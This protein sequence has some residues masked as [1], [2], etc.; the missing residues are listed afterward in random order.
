MAFY[1]RA[2]MHEENVTFRD[3]TGRQEEVVQERDAVLVHF[4]DE[5]GAC[6]FATEMEAMGM[7]SA[8][9][10]G[11]LLWSERHFPLKAQRLGPSMLACEVV[12]ALDRVPFFVE[13]A[14]RLGRRFGVALAFEVFVARGEID[15]R[16]CVVIASF[17][18]NNERFDYYLRLV[19][20]QLLTRAGVRLGARPYGFGIWNSPFLRRVFSAQE[21]QAMLRDKRAADPHGLLNPQKFFSVRSRMHNIPGLL[22]LPPVYEGLLALGTLLAPILGF[23]ARTFASSVG[24]P[25]Q[26][27][28]ED[29]ADGSTLVK[30]T[31]MRC[32]SCGACISV[33]PAFLVTGREL[34]AGRAKLKIAR[35]VL[36]RATITGSEVATA[37]QCLHCGLC[38]EVCQTRLP[39]RACYRVLERWAIRRYGLPRQVIQEFVSRVD[40]QR[41]RVLGAYGLARAEWTPP[42]PPLSAAVDRQG[43]GA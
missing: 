43:V 41:L 1:D 39:L 25:W 32:A 14:R 31:E 2:R 6:R 21:R 34:V 5:E 40:E 13:K 35:A 9:V 7:V 37:F 11:S 8:Q 38:E 17:L 15:E 12:L 16:N 27:P 23:V 3:K 28:S 42:V 29:D 26:T 30:E 18:C 36:E 19:L 4:D 10:G 24:Q 33:C 20:V 22:F